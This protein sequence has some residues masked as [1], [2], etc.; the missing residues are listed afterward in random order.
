MFPLQNTKEEILLSLELK[1]SEDELNRQKASV[2]E[3]YDAE[4]E[5]LKNRHEVEKTVLDK[6]LLETIKDTLTG[7]DVPLGMVIH[8]E[9]STTI[10]L[11]EFKQTVQ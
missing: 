3:K 8:P 1:Y 7:N 2:S 6:C 4:L 5:T 9:Y 10:R 11:D